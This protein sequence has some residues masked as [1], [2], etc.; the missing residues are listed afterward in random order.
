[1]THPSKGLY[2]QVPFTI[3][4]PPGSDDRKNNSIL[5]LKLYDLPRLRRF[6]CHLRPYLLK[7]EIDLGN[8]A[9]VAYDVSGHLM[10]MQHKIL[11]SDLRSSHACDS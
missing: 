10:L 7:I 9:I 5:F 4:L 8:R 1:M 3:Q 11:G 2:A 6:D